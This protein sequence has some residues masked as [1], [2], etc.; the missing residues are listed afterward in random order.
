[1]KKCCMSLCL[2]LAV[3]AIAESWGMYERL[4]DDVAEEIRESV[5]DPKILK[6]AL[7]DCFAGEHFLWDR[8][9]PLYIKKFDIAEDILRAVLMEIIHE[10]EKA[11]KWEPFRNEDT[12]ELTEEKRRLR[13]SIE[14]LGFCA[15]EPAKAFL[16]EIAA[17]ETK[18]KT[19]RIT[20][21]DAYLRRADAQQVKD[22]LIRFLIGDMRIDAYLTY[23]DAMEAYDAAED[24]PQKRAAIVSALTAAALE[25]EEDRGYFAKADE[26]FAGQD[27]GY[28]QSPQRKKALERMNMPSGKQGAGSRLWL[29]AGVFLCALCATLCLVRR[30]KKIG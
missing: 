11:A 16:M 24:D 20:A 8:E 6:E 27:T 10:S 21:A 25:K 3:H 29:Y 17:D 1:M 19:Y 30:K 28:A 4:P 7:V 26:H 18:A 14:W 12:E 22:A 2:F 15:D 5:K 13:R 9:I 23:L